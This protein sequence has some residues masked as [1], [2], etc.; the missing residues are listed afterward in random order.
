ML[1]RLLFKLKSNRLLN[2]GADGIRTRDL[3]RGRLNIKNSY[4]NN[5]A[6]PSTIQRD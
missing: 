6:L 2:G 5:L 1:K 4:F 3:R